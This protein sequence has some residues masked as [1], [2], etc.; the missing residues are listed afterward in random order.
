MYYIYVLVSL[1]PMLIIFLLKSD[2]NNWLWALLIC[3]AGFVFSKLYIYL[4]T[5]KASDEH[6]SIKLI[7]T[8]EDKYMTLYIVCFVISLNINDIITFFIV[9]FIVFLFVIKAKFSYF[10]PYLM[11][12]YNFYEAEIENKKSANY[13]ICLISKNTIKN[14]KLA[15][16]IRLNN[17]VFLED[18]K[19]EVN[20]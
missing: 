9:Y 2:L 15:N 7:E 8:A 3:V 19:K 4:H 6:A 13:K 14:D 16:L 11:L 20:E 5:R 10:N 1:T 17:F 18:Y 12:W